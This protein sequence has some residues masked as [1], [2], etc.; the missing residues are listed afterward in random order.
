[1][2]SYKFP[3]GN[4]TDRLYIQRN[5]VHASAPLNDLYI[6]NKGTINFSNGDAI[7]THSNQTLDI[8]ANNLTIQGLPFFDADH[9]GVFF[10]KTNTTSPAIHIDNSGNFKFYKTVDQSNNGLDLAALYAQH[11]VSSSDITYKKTIKP[12]QNSKNIISQLNP[13]YWKWKTNNNGSCGLI[14]QDVATVVPEAVMKTPH[15]LGI[16]YNYFIGLLISRL[17]EYDKELQKI[18]NHVGLF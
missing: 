16:N 6:S 2:R 10:R 15:G 9:V 8:S 3:D 7:L 4:I 17:Q 18:Y 11:Y 12:I 13:V 14:A 5:G 1:M